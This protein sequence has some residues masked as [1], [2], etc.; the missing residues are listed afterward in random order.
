MNLS[1]LDI[2]LTVEGVSLAV[3]CYA[4]LSFSTNLMTSAKV[5]RFFLYILDAIVGVS[6]RPLTKIQ[7]VTV[8]LSK[9][10]HFAAALK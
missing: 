2:I 1:L 3:S 8:S 10:H 6:L 9:A 5:W 7:I 4:A